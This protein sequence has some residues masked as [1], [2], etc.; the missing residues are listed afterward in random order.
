MQA[1][2]LGRSVWHNPGSAGHRHLKVQEYIPIEDRETVYM[3]V[4]AVSSRNAIPG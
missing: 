1:V 2:N 4:E 3:S